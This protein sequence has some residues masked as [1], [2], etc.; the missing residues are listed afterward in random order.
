MRRRAVILTAAAM[1]WA[2][3]LLPAGC[4]PRPADETPNAG[5]DFSLPTFDSDPIPVSKH[6][7]FF[8][9]GSVTLSKRAR[10]TLDYQAATMKTFPAGRFQI[11]GRTDTHETPSV[12]AS[13]GLGYRRAMIVRDYLE[14]M[15]VPSDRL[16]LCSR[17]STGVIVLNESDESMAHLRSVS[18]EFV[19]GRNRC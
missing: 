3:F 9:S 5:A 18:T 13:F 14:S 16:V 1:T 7:V 12:D 19:H 17:G 10:K 4:A 6:Q 8:E 11:V 15:G 2:A